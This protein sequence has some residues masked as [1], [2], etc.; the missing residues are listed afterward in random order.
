VV[1]ERDEEFAL[2]DECELTDGTR[3]RCAQ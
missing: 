1:A 2:E 3:I